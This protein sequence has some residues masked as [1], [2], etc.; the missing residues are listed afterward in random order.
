MVCPHVAGVAAL[1]WNHLRET[2]T[3]G[4][5]VAAEVMHHIM[6]AARKADA[7]TGAY[8]RFA[9][10]AG[11]GTVP[12]PE[13]FPFPLPT[14]RTA[15][16]PPEAHA[17]KIARRPR[18]TALVAEPGKMATDGASILRSLWFCENLLRWCYVSTVLVHDWEFAQ[19]HA[20]ASAKD[21]D[22]VRDTLAG[23][24]KTLMEANVRPES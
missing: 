18:E 16:S 20:S 8:S 7:F 15:M 12:Q 22:A 13:L 3:D 14:R 6:A 10:G 24:V 4:H 17:T 1:W 21:F 2:N 9:Y 11:Q 5:A 23:G 19:H